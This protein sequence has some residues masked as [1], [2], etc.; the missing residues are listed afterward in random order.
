MESD[1]DDE[2]P[3]DRTPAPEKAPPAPAADSSDDDL[4]PVDSGPV[5]SDFDLM[6]QKRKEEN[7]MKR[8][9]NKKNEG[10]FISDV[11]DS[12]NSMMNRMKEA[13]DADKG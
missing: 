5:V 4:G 3:V 12:I 8:M 2:G 6:M 10:A 9:K 7:R 13:A 11:D 1:S